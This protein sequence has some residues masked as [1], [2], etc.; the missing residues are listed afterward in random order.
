MYLGTLAVNLYLLYVSMN[1]SSLSPH[2][3]L[4]CL[5]PIIVELVIIG[6][7]SLQRLAQIRG[8]T[9]RPEAGGTRKR[10]EPQVVYHLIVLMIVLYSKVHT[11]YYLVSLIL[12]GIMYHFECASLLAL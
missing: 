5:F 4:L 1:R 7:Y 3:V 2:N 6:P 8:I 12:P 10:D 11:A 9:P